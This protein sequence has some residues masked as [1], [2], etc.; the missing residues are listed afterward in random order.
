MKRQ[1]LVPKGMITRRMQ[2]AQATWLR[3]DYP[4][5]IEI[6]EGA[7]RLAPSDPE[8]LIALGRLN[9]WRY[10]YEAAAQWFDK[11][12]RFAPRKTEMLVN[13]GEICKNLRNLELAERYWQQ[14]TKQPDATAAALAKLA[15][16]YERLRRLPE[17]AELV[18]RALTKEPG[19]PAARL[20]H[21]RLERLSGR[22]ETAE[23]ELRDLLA[24]PIADA[25]T[26]GQSLYE[27][28]NVLDREE[29]YDEAMA[30]FLEAK[31]LLCPKPD[32]HPA[33][34]EALNAAMKSI[35]SQISAEMVR[36]WVENG[37]ALAPARRVAVLCGYQRSGTTLLEQV[38][39][40]HP[41][42]V[43]AEETNVFL[44]DGLG[45]LQRNLPRDTPV[46]PLL[47]AATV[48][49]LQAARAGYFRF[50]ELAHGSPFTGR[51][52]IDKNPVLTSHLAAFVRV[53]PEARLLVALRDPRDVVL[54]SFMLPQRQ[55]AAK[56]ASLSLAAY[57]ENYIGVMRH[58]RALAPL[59]PVPWLEVRY[60]DMVADL[61]PVARKALDFLGVPWDDRVLAFH[62]TARKKIVRS[63]TYADVTQ[64]VYQR[65]RGRWRHYQ[66]YLEPYLAKLEPFVKA[67]GYE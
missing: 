56:E 29:K 35:E 4:A 47:D 9:G 23:K 49:A 1:Q 14:A 44:E 6:L 30:A 60:E 3:K 16:L 25:W 2:E 28:G 26:H 64:P 19:C 24:K 17:A 18:E 62:E 27:L 59:M 37:P 39:D 33:K 5:A 48:P 21:A 11:V 65:A 8:T 66:K 20:V 57:V 13:I 45:L 53:L 31:S 46:V 50:L 15:D 38:L 55:K 54:S 58:W 12:L 7:H 63:P 40:G 10:N 42:I 36:R 61:E 67:F 51:M 52:V 32:P 22:W 41:D 43:S 34:I